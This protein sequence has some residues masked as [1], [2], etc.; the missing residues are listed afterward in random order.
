MKPTERGGREHLATTGFQTVFIL[1]R[2]NNHLRIRL[3]ISR[4][5]KKKV[6]Y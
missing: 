5:G 1:M 2:P 6:H 4:S 3:D